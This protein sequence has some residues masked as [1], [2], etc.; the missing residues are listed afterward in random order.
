MGKDK[1]E[2]GNV[3]A[4]GPGQYTIGGSFIET[5]VKVGDHVVLPTQGFT[6]LEHDGEVY[7][8]GPE[9]QILAKLKK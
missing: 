1:N 5:V 8:V 2:H 3:V 4:V 7:Y 9:N 6:K